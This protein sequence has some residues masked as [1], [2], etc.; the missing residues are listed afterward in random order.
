MPYNIYASVMFLADIIH[1]N[2]KRYREIIRISTKLTYTVCSVSNG[3][4]V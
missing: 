1:V 3:K 4:A 2:T